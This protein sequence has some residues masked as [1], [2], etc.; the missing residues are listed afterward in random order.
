VRGF[1]QNY[2]EVMQRAFLEMVPK[3]EEGSAGLA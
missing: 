1:I 2:V 3:L